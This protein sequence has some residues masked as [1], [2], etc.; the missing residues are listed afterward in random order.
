MI[1]LSK[2]DLEKL[3]CIR[4]KYSLK[5]ILLCPDLKIALLKTN[6]EE[7]INMLE[8]YKDI[9]SVFPNQKLDKVDLTYISPVMLRTIANKA[10][11]LAGSQAELDELQRQAFH[12]YND[13]LPYIQ[14]GYL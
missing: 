4:L 13:Y 9:D 1:K 10:E 8:L 11:I 3:E 14:Q 6:P 12:L 5:L 2:N 7:S